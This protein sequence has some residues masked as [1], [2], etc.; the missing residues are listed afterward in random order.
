MLLASSL[1]DINNTVVPLTTRNGSCPSLV[2]QYMGMEPITLYVGAV[3]HYF[4]NTGVARYAV[5]R[6]PSEIAE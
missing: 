2:I 3:E 4:Q 5:S 6:M 1:N